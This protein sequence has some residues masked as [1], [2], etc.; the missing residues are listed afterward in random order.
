M[1]AAYEILFRLENQ[2]RRF[3]E[4]K[5]RSK[6]GP[7]WWDRRVSGKVQAEALNLRR[8]ETNL[9]W[10]VSQSEN[11]TDYLQFEHLALIIKNN[12]DVFKPVFHK[13]VEI[14]PRLLQLES[15]LNSIAHARILTQDGMDR[16]YKYSNDI[17][18][19]V[20]PG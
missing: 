16:L 12:W 17:T 5:L 4:S 8:S 3:I 6:Y 18:N 7:E 19:M 1:S 10:K 9:S 14:A 13:E 20:M 15:I 2:L 11:I